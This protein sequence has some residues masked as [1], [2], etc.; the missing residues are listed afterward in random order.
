MFLGSSFDDDKKLAH[1]M[2]DATGIRCST[3]TVATIK[4]LQH[5]K[6]KAISIAVPY[7]EATTAKVVDFFKNCSYEVAK[8]E[9]L[10]TVPPL[11]VEIAKSRPSDIKDVIKRSMTSNTQAIVIACTNWPASGLVA[12]LEEELGVPIVDSISVTVWWALRM[13]GVKASI[14]GWGRLFELT[15]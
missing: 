2:Q 5:L 13:A 10:E 1:A 15:A 14:P 7:N 6:A 11:N 12:E 4:A 8:A 9:R 3:T